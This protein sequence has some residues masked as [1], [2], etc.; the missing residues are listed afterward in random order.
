VGHAGL[1]LRLS[2]RALARL[3]AA[4]LL[5]SGLT[6]G[7][8]SP[9]IEVEALATDAAVLQI[10][11]QR[12]MLRVGQSF[13]GVTLIAA[14]SRTA[15]LEIEGERIVLGISR[16]IGSNYEEPKAQVVEIRR[17]ASLQYQTR[18]T[19]NGHAVQVL[20]DTGANVVAINSTQARQLG[21]DYESGSQARVE[22]ASGRV[23][24]W[25]VTLRTVNVGG[26]KVENVQATVLEGDFPS[27]ILLGMTYLQHVDIKENGGV[28]S[29]SRSW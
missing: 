19:I 20:V 9:R 17:D 7:A 11:G 13:Q 8:E 14:Y 12:K 26:I 1:V 27:T 4:A 25:G 29:L 21:V 24:G 6:S 23:R 16:R 22:T 5:F 3:A 18:A 10:D 28:L 15:T 2:A